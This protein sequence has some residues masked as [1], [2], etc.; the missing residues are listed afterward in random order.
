MATLNRQTLLLKTAIE[1]REGDPAFREGIVPAAFA[2]GEQ[3]ADAQALRSNL[4]IIMKGRVQLVHAGPNGR[5]LTIAILDPGTSFGDAPLGGQGDPNAFAIALT[6][7]SIWRITAAHAQA[8]ILSYPALSLGLLQ[9]RVERLAQVENRMEEVAYKRLP[10]RLAGLLLELSNGSR[11]IR[12][13]S[14]QAL[15]DMLGTYR[16]TISAI[17]RGFKDAGLVELGYRKIELR[18]VR[19]LRAAAGSIE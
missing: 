15:A 7:C 14:H 12:G 13:T 3:I 5:Y 1:L 19:G 10:E 2:S 6:N 9:N 18:D 4:Y 11:A 16:E 17:L 8:M